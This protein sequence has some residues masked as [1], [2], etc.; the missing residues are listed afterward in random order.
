MTK[1]P[2]KY[3]I[4][5]APAFKTIL[6]PFIQWKIKKGFT[7]VEAYTD[8]S[9]VGTTTT[10][11]KA[12]IKGLYDAG[13]TT[14][15][16]PTFVLFVG[17]IA[18]IPT[19]TGTTDNSHVTDLN[20]CEYTSD[21][22]PEIYYGRFSAT[23][24]TE[25]QPQ[26]DKTLQYEQ[27]TMPDP[28]FL[29]NCVM[30]S[31]ND[32]EGG[33]Y[34]LT[35]G[36]GQ[37]N[38]GTTNYF[39]TAH[40]LTSYTYLYATSSSNASVIRQKISDGVCFANYTAHGDW[41][42]WYN[43]SFTVSNVA[44]MTNTNKYPLMIGN[45]CLSNKFNASSACFGEAL[46][47]ASGKGAVGYIGASNSSLWDED[48]Y[49]GVGYRSTISAN[50]T[51]SATALGEYDRV[52]HDH[53]EAFSDWYTTMDQMIYA[54]NL[55]VTQSGSSDYKYYWEIYCLMGDP[56][57]M[58]YFGVPS[59]L[60]A[61]YDPIV[62]GQTTFTVNTQ[63]YAYVAISQ[64][65]VLYGAALADAS[66]VA[67]IPITPFSAMGTADVVATKQNR[68]PFISTVSIGTVSCAEYNENNN[69]L[70]CYPNPF[71]SSTT[72]NYSLKNTSD[73]SI[74]IYNITGQQVAV[75]YDGKNIQAGTYSATYNADG[76]K[77]G[78]YHCVL[79]IG[80]K[81]LTQKLILR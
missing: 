80:N 16:A 31:G 10:S 66:G 76:L 34:S 64:S 54:G 39:N 9:A 38:Y 59:A 81:V 21:Y 3:V 74:K 30:I 29:G 23:S 18:Q 53:S 22:M 60:T 37:I 79:T 35:N 5:S 4:V 72:I 20:Y 41:D 15:P 6:Q 19:F 56:S 51:Y 12:Y 45:C 13:T 2:V 24:T 78:I 62:T 73:V 47:R 1:Y 67:V 28:S 65:G 57:L 32:E 25:L 7:V 44:S 8:N 77:A 27:Y 58:I 68:S 48:F 43:P 36:D 63:P 71:N 26:I 55:A 11:I 49:F 75:V 40:G 61:T 14:N 52:F 69:T 50:P 17:D 42:R 33:T 70:S 46:L